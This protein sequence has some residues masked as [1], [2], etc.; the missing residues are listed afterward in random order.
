MPSQRCRRP[1]SNLFWLSLGKVV[2]PWVNGKD[3]GGWDLSW[4]HLPMAYLSDYMD[5]MTLSRPAV[6]LYEEY[7]F[8]EITFFKARMSKGHNKFLSL[9]TRMY[10]NHWT[11]KLVKDFL[12]RCYVTV[13]VTKSSDIIINQ[14]ST[15]RIINVKMYQSFL[16]ETFLAFV[17]LFLNT[18]SVAWWVMGAN[19]QVIAVIR[20]RPSPARVSL[21]EHASTAVRY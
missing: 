7:I 13:T 10:P 15:E 17:D 5:T 12:P 8:R 16:M 11:L 20:V 19:G 1:P 18:N 2:R 6:A 3:E 4:E 9:N 14:N 21:S